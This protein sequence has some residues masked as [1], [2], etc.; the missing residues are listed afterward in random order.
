[1]LL[2]LRQLLVMGISALHQPQINLLEQA[3]EL[4][5]RVCENVQQTNQ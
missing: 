2:P 3:S 5:V 4:C 1:M